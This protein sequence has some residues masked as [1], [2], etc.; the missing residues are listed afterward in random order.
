MLQFRLEVVGAAE[1]REGLGRDHAA[2]LA[3]LRAACYSACLEARK[4]A[5]ENLSGRVMRRRGVVADL[6]Q[7]V[8]RQ[9]PEAHAHGASWGLPAEGEGPTLGPAGGQL[10]L[11]RIGEFFERGGVVRPVRA[12]MLR[13]PIPD[14][15]ALTAAGYDRYAGTRLR[16]VPGFRL[17]RRRGDGKLFLVHEDDG[18]AWYV[19]KNQT[20]VRPHPWFSSA[21][22]AVR[23]RLDSIMGPAAAEEVR[24]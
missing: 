13:I 7:F 8:A 4:E 17:A 15:P 14:G 6:A 18:R 20:T 16:T 19:L 24:Q 10:P 21:V 1:A 9:M 22:E 12:K 23:R 3:R 11:S 5:L 2:L